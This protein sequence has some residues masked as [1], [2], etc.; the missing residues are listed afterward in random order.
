MGKALR[1]LVW[2]SLLFLWAG[3]AAD[4]SLAAPVQQGT[5]LV[6]VSP[7]ACPIGGCAAGQRMNLRFDFELINYS[8][9]DSPNVKVC[10]YAPTSWALTPDMLDTVVGELTGKNYQRVD[11][12]NEDTAQPTGYSLVMAREASIDST[13]F[14]D[15]VPLAFRFASTSS[16][17]GRIVARLF[18]KPE[19]AGFRRT[20]H[21]TTATLSVAPRANH[22]YVAND[23][24]ACGSN[25]PCYIN[26]G[27]DLP[28]GVGTG[29]R[30]AVEASA[31]ESTLDILGVYRVKSNVVLI[32][33]PLT[34][35]GINDAAITSGDSTQCS[36]P[37]LSLRDAVTL[38]SLNINDGSCASPG[39]SLVEINSSQAVAIESNDLLNGDN[40]IFIRDNS[41]TVSV[42]FN[43][44][45]GNTG[46]AVFAEGDS[47]GG[48]LNVMANN[49]QGNRS[50]AAILCSATG[51]GVIGNR[52]VNHNYWG[53]SAPG[54][55]ESHCT[56]SA[57]KRLGAPIAL[58]SSA[59]GV[60]AQLVTVGAS[61]TYAFEN[62]IAYERIGGLDFD[63]Y[64][65][66]HGYTLENGAP[67]TTAAGGDSPSPC[68]NIWDVFLPDGVSPAGTLALYFKYDKTPACLAAINTNKYCDQTATPANYP[69][70][71]FDPA[72]N[73]VTKWWDTTGQRPENLSSGEGQATTCDTENSEIRVAIDSDGRPNLKDDLNYTPLMVGVPVLRTFLPL[74]SSQTITVTWTTNSEPDIA[75]FY[76][77]RS[78]DGKN[79]TP[80]SDLI[81]RRGSA[82]AGVTS[83]PYSFV[84][85]G[86]TNRVTYSYRLQVVRTD[87]QSF[88]SVIYK[89]Q[90]NV[91]TITPTFTASPT[92]TS[93]I[94]RPTNTLPATRIPTQ[95][96]TAIP[97]RTMTPRPVSTTATS[98]V[99]G[100]PTPFGFSG[101]TMYPLGTLDETMA[102]QM[103]A[104]TWIPRQGSGTPGAASSSAIPAGGAAT[105]TPSPTPSGTILAP[106]TI[107][108]GRPAAWISLLLGALASLAVIGVTGGWWYY[109]IKG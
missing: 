70:F 21:S 76:V 67:F 56:F 60:D 36:Q 54:A 38:S 9:T 28:N 57:A 41:G 3:P 5:A 81:A 33:K 10:F 91:A 71:W 51:S 24:A 58:K 53:A 109:R 14:S 83:P 4:G 63:L 25:S 66:N 27:D 59:P 73:S 52:K 106:L 77:L 107:E 22:A 46:Y 94:P 75:G 87:G 104:G 8:P 20:Q 68:S 39:R 18:E 2:I 30:D 40:A 16:G 23:A 69:L 98:F 26:S 85:A 92:R 47:A 101:G 48:A 15:S 1:W 34:V 7:T 61:K 97:T 93:T 37:L 17:N 44:I 88:Y 100:T 55:D 74:A 35:R 103:T 96:P 50:G 105:A 78:M 32:D 29:L 86:R 11:N 108:T 65:V 12:C 31:S 102:A 43:R 80:I 95:R 90:A 84:D 19:G 6:M 79:F 82:L 13:T 64:I 42:R 99:L 72:S 45:N 89:L 62:Q 49:L